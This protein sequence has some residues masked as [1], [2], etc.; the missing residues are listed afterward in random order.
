MAYLIGFA[1]SWFIGEWI[2]GGLLW[3]IFGRGTSGPDR[4]TERTFIW[5]GRVIAFLI[6]IIIINA[7]D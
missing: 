4:Y 6:A 3:A 5:L 7:K 1:A 2:I